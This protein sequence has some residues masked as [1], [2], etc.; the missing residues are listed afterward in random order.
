MFWRRRWARIVFV[1]AAVLAAGGIT[2]SAL[3]DIEPNSTHVT[4]SASPHPQKLQPMVSAKP[5]K[6]RVSTSESPLSTKPTRQPS[7]VGEVTSMRSEFSRVLRLSNGSLRV[8]SSPS[9]LFYRGDGGWRPINDTLRRTGGG[10]A[11][12]G[13]S[14]SAALGTAP[15]GLTLSQGST[16]ITVAPVAAA[17][18]GPR[19]VSASVVSNPKRNSNLSASPIP[20]PGIAQWTKVWNGLDL[21]V[22]VQSGGVADDVVLRGPDSPPSVTFRVSGTSLVE[23]RDGSVG[24]VGPL[25]GQLEIPPP[26]VT[27]ADGADT[28]SASGVSYRLGSGGLLTVGV[29]P[30]WLSSLRPESFPVVIDPYFDFDTASAVVSYPSSGSGTFP[31]SDQ[32]Q[33]GGSGTVW[34]AAAEFGASTDGSG[35]TLDSYE[36]EGYRA[37]Q[38]Y[39]TLDPASGGNETGYDS[40][41]GTSQSGCPTTVINVFGQGAE[42]TKESQV[43]AGSGACTSSTPTAQATDPT[44]QG[45]TF[46][47]GPFIG[48]EVDCWLTHDLKSQ[49]LG[50][51]ES[52]YQGQA[53]PVRDYQLYFTTLLEFLPPASR[54]VNLARNSVLTT[55][56]PALQASPVSVTA[57]QCS[58]GMFPTYDYEVTTGPQPNSGLVISS[59]EM[60]D[61]NVCPTSGTDVPP[62][63]TVPAGALKE[64]VS[65]HAWVLT[66]WNSNG[67]GS[68]YGEGVPQTVPPLSWGVPFTV[69]LGLGAGGAMA[70]DSV[71]SVP[72]QSSTPS[73][74]AP[75]PGLP[76]SK[77]T[78]NMVDGNASMAIA[79][80][81][82]ATVG[83]GLAVSFTYNSLDSAASSSPGLEGSYYDT[84]SG[85]PVLVAQ[86][87]DPT[88]EFPAGSDW[89]PAAESG[90]PGSVTWTGTLSLPTTGGISSGDV[91]AL[92]EISSDGMT[93]S[94][95]SN[96]SYLV[97]GAGTGPTPVYGPSISDTGQSLAVT[98]T[99]NRVG[100]NPPAA[101]LYLRDA[102][103]GSV[104]SV[105]PSWLS[106]S[107]GPL[108]T[109][110]T[111]N[112][113]AAQASWIGLSDQGSSVTLYRADGS[114]YEFVNAG[115]G[116]YSPPADDP[117]AELRSA[118]G[119][120]F[121]LDDSGLIYNFNPSGQLASVTSAANDLKPAALTYTYSGS[122]AQ[123]TSIIDPVSNNPS[124]NDRVTSFVYGPSSSC[125][126]VGTA[127]PSGMLCAINFWN[128]TQTALFYNSYGELVEIQDPGPYS[129][130]FAYNS[131]AQVDYEVDPIVAA[132]VSAGTGPSNCPATNQTA[133]ATAI[134]YYA[135]GK[136]ANV[137]SPEPANGAARPERY[138]CYGYQY[139]NTN[140]GYAPAYPALDTTSMGVVGLYPPILSA[141]GNTYG[142][143]QQDSYDSQGR[144]TATRD[145]TGQTTSYVWNSSDQL[146]STVG[147]DG[148]ETS[149][150]YDNQER[151]VNAYGPAP[152][153]SFMANGAPAGGYSVPT[154]TTAY[155]GGLTGLAA[156]W[157]DNTSLAGAPVYHSTVPST[158]SWSASTS[159]STGTA[160]PG[161]VNSSGYSGKLTGQVTLTSPQRLGFD[162]DGG[163]VSIDGHQVIDQAGGPYPA[164]VAADS[165]ADWW[166]LGEAPGASIAAD[167]SGSDPGSYGSG[168]TLG[169]AG[170]LADGDS[171]AAAFNGTT[172]AVVTTPSA[173][174]DLEIG[175]GEPFSIEAWVD[176]SDKTTTEAIV[177]DLSPSYQGYG[178]GLTDG[179]PYFQLYGT[180]SA[181]IG[182]EGV[183]A[184]S[185]G[186]HHLVFTYNG[187]GQASGVDI[188][189]D[190]SALNSVQMATLSNTLGS[191][192]PASATPV[193][194]GAEAGGYNFNGDLADVAIY[195]NVI[196]PAARVAAHHSAAALTTTTTTGPIVYDTPYPEAVEAD[197]PI[198][199]WRLD[200][201]SGATTATDSWAGEQNGTY[202]NV[203]LGQAGP[204]QGDSSTAAAFN[205]TTSSV[206]IPDSPSLEMANTQAFSADAWIKT[207]STAQQVIAS[208]LSASPVYQGWEFGV[209]QGG[210][211]LILVNSWS[212]NAIDVI[213]SHTVNDGA[214]H[215]VAV[216]YDG[217]STG[218][219][220]IFYVDGQTVS[221]TIAVNSLN[222][223]S[224]SNAPLT[225]GQRPSNVYPFNGD[226]SDVAIYRNQLS[227]DRIL[228]HYQA[229]AFTPYLDAASADTPT[230]MWQLGEAKTSEPASD[231]FGP[232]PGSYIGGITPSGN[233]ATGSSF[234]GT[235][236]SVTIPDSPSL[237]VGQNQPVSLEAWVDQPTAS[238]N[239]QTI[240]AQMTNA[241]PFAGWELGVVNGEPYF[242]LISSYPSNY[243]LVAANQSIAGGNHQVD[244]TYDGSSSAAGVHFYIDGKPVAATAYA[245]TLTASPVTHTQVSIGSR[246]D[247][248]LWFNGTIND[249]AFYA[250]TLTAGQIAKHYMGR[251][252]APGA[253]PY[254]NIHTV[255]VTDQQYVTGGGYSITASC[256]SSNDCPYTAA[257]TGNGSY[258]PDYGLV[259]STTDP[260][261]KTTTTAYTQGTPGTAGYIDPAYGLATTTT[262]DPAGLA[263]TTTTG[264]EPP[265][266]GSYLRVVSKT[267]PAGNQ[268]TYVNY[269]GYAAA[270]SCAA[271]EQP[272]AWATACG[273]TAGADQWGEVAER[274]DPP[275]AAGAGYA[276]VEQYLYDSTGRQVGVRVGS[277]NTIP[278]S[279]W[280][281]TAYD[282]VGRMTSQSFPAFDGQPART[283]TYTYAV[284]G[285]PQVNSVTDTNW[286]G[287]AVTST[288][289]LD[290]RIVSYS[291]IYANTTTSTYDQVGRVTQTSGPQG[292]LNYCFDSAGRPSQT[293]LGG[294][295]AAPGTVLAAETYDSYGR[296]ATVANSDGVT[297]TLSYDSAGRLVGHSIAAPAGQ[298]TTGE[299]D[300]LDAAGRVTNQQVYS[301]SNG[302]LVDANPGGVDY[303]Y[304]GAG[305]LTQAAL[306][307]VTYNYG[308]GASSNCPAN[309]A[310]ENTNRTTLTVSGTGAGTTN[311]CYDNADRLVSTSTIPASQIAYD[312]HGNT[313]QEGNQT[314]VYDSSDQLIDTA[315]PTNVTV[316][317]RDPLDRIAAQTSITPISEIGATTAT[318]A[319]ANS[320]NLNEPAG[321]APGD[322]ELAAVTDAT[323]SPATAPAGWAQVASTSN[324]STITEAGAGTATA[325]SAGAVTVTQPANTQPGDSEIAAV[326]AA[327]SPGMPTTLGLPSGW[328]QIAA[329]TNTSTITEAGSSTAATASG[330]NVNIAAPS[331]GRPGDT[332]IASITA[333]TVSPVT[334]PTGWTDVT[335]AANQSPITDGGATTKTVTA[336]STISLTDPAGVV[337]GDA[338]I[339]A[340]TTS[341]GSCTSPSGWS[342]VTSTSNT[343]S[344]SC[345]FW[346][347]SASGDQTSWTFNVNSSTASIV[348]SLVDYHNAANNP[349][350]V[351]NAANDSTST[352]QP[353]PAVTTSGADETLVH[354]VGYTG[355][356]TPTAP[357]GDT[358]EEAT[359]STL[360]SQLVSDR[361]QAQAGPSASATA[362]SNIPTTSEALTVALQPSANTTTVFAHQVTASDPANW[363]F[364]TAAT[365][366]IEA[367]L[368]DY[369]D[370]APGAVDVSGTVTDPSSTSQPL[371]VVTTTN[372]GEQVVH[373][374]GY[375]GD[376]SGYAPGGDTQRALLSGS[377]ASLMVS[378]YN[379]AQ[380][381]PSVDYGAGSSAA[382]PADA[383]T[384]ALIPETNTTW[385]AA[386]QVT[387][388][389]PASWTF[390]LGANTNLAANIVDYHSSAPNPIDVYAASADSSSTNQPLPVVTTSG[391][392]EQVVHIVGYNGDVSGY[393]PGGDT[394]RTLTPGPDASLMVSDYEQAQ[395]GQSVDYDAGSSGPA[396]AEAFTVALIPQTDTTAVYWHQATSSDP[397]SWT[398]T[399]PATT[400]AAAELVDYRGASSNPIDVYTSATDAA[401]ANQAL[402]QVTTSGPAET[403]FHVVGYNANTTSSAPGGESQR[404]MLAN[405]FA[406]LQTSDRL[407]IQPGL[408][409]AAT[410]TTATATASEEITVALIPAA[411]TTQRLGYD[412][413]TDSS[414]FTQSTSGTVTG[415]S[416]GLPAGVTYATTPNSTVWSYTN[417]H[418]DTITTTDNTGHITW[419]GFW[420]PYGENAS[421]NG[422]PSDTAIAGGSYGYNGAQGKLTDGNLIF[423]GS[424]PYQPTMGRFI[425]PDPIEGGCAN[426]Y[427]YA[428]GDPLNHPDLSG[429]G[430]CNVLINTLPPPLGPS[431]VIG[432]GAYT[433]V[434]T[435]SGT[436]NIYSTEVVGDLGAAASSVFDQLILPYNQWD[437]WSTSPNSITVLAL[438]QLGEGYYSLR[439][440]SSDGTPA[441]DFTTD[442]GYVAPYGDNVT[443]HFSPVTC[444]PSSSTVAV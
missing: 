115:N 422:P 329:K 360:V 111:L 88:V 380:A 315:S 195:P 185:S 132:A 77:L 206:S 82:L 38:S 437:I 257:T 3:A 144:L 254:A 209:F 248:G 34:A 439:D 411:I 415:V 322:T 177:S 92:G 230:S 384:V 363:T 383:I 143:V 62:S 18:H 401:S 17:G 128:G 224:V 6:G 356:A 133:C 134:G 109:G 183:S 98:V 304:D 351:H 131:A 123:V 20:Q 60:E 378:D 23:N 4:R 196:L 41:C 168:V 334:G 79:T 121:V 343:G 281:C 389:D 208:K 83:G 94:L 423:M 293:I 323:A 274:T 213:T 252:T 393:A 258:D 19:S 37:Y 54:V 204:L 277:V 85:H 187:S 382:A 193:T 100:T 178:V 153:G 311:Y 295:C 56:Q 13:N 42:P 166:R 392:Q 43:G 341:S 375:E 125:P 255:T 99:W 194:V 59:G 365:T 302:G 148:T 162:G 200:E 240:I 90:N 96:S 116:T 377:F 176:S 165:P 234:N 141:N 186:W 419:T 413:Q 22:S 337:P 345:V 259:T 172:S 409:A 5:A 238:S 103:G 7:V 367:S 63:W 118:A 357:A 149:S 107:P 226:I 386:H 340:V 312:N 53:T 391:S 40:S 70:T 402:P 309:N 112:D 299:L 253:G 117:T 300:T 403:I 151:T 381:G 359:T 316:Y 87:V 236:G 120:N 124:S 431:N 330:N 105:S 69:K 331:G 192:N 350:D 16:S 390:N 336:S 182:V 35:N 290:D 308:Y 256:S 418:G 247:N 269:C 429:K 354:V 227:A 135:N 86:R 55:T 161:L 155:D 314:F 441:I 104:W 400:Y 157:Y 250:Q 355:D 425:Q 181:A 443:L 207:S 174:P 164:A 353:L 11:T 167:N 47:I 327:T 388:T 221:S 262:Q 126:N 14:W 233:T 297:E 282:S 64:G 114:G 39:V 228:A 444:N 160:E 245:N 189:V 202:S 184:L 344:T 78:V 29:S 276:I 210:L 2:S 320:V 433:F 27:T 372:P 267:L 67:T 406:S 73:T 142:Y 129:Y 214:W 280:A 338:L 136:V 287:A 127:P 239:P 434:Q 229:G 370:T 30:S 271:P 231:L 310:G 93:V 145:S 61:V 263:L 220:V 442:P 332:I 140:G 273:V 159:P 222:A 122:P 268:T 51:T 232:N 36:G 251:Q 294:T 369:Q 285:N 296:L 205:G 130:E 349:I 219:G 45:L 32:I 416:I 24:L 58:D 342:L 420:G 48:P 138:Y 339:A 289:D 218:G 147:P 292:T 305:R 438:G 373:I 203:A 72:G 12:S 394:Q 405:L 91:V 368:V 333:A 298:P 264:Y 426:Q 428:F 119:G 57:A 244:V 8:D 286:P 170:P 272:G 1:T 71:G 152:S 50:F 75:S 89:Q 412:G 95:G 66:D 270:A 154:S 10:L 246:D 158:D 432:V 81:T 317:Q 266:P 201:A 397:S 398:F 306:P 249:V 352:S 33:I 385:I 325:V 44:P 435:R 278:S 179:L 424:R 427:T 265:G 139:C 275:P 346:H 379:Q 279:G 171:T 102:T 283:V 288:V 101:E 335:S 65:Y 410:A 407:Q 361:L 216:T 436:R 113:N 190:G 348:A 28:T 417:N 198:G 52:S 25:A 97:E 80:P 68:Y 421:G 169:Q 180:S 235:S 291:D 366:N 326:N 215:H 395:A 223:T 9:P 387:A 191:T 49:W 188:Y 318:A 399:L 110:W 241:S 313:I 324:T 328:N 319:P 358:K 414:G 374:V 46:Q 261:G 108:P 260:D 284:G 301:A 243:I 106:H 237:E 307:G 197:S 15:T 440:S 150:A 347:Q 404:S 31:Y 321:V 242:Y 74:G 21:R 199:Y 364:T 396:A 371:P 146:V 376:V 303:L 211:Y 76:G 408:S 217:S 163:T 225:I 84:V 26:R 212:G 430:T 362:T 173:V 156:A 175:T 137:T